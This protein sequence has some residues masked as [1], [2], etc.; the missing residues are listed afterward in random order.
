MHQITRKIF[1]YFPLMF[2][3]DYLANSMFF[4]QQFYPVNYL[5]NIALEHAR[6]PFV[7]LSD[8]DFV[9]MPGTYSILR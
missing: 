8:V 2:Y 4:F 7:F 1:A 9:P 6:T 3:H 5:R